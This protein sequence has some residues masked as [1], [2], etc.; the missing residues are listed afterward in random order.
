M[1]RRTAVK[2]RVIRTHH[3]FFHY[4]LKLHWSASIFPGAAV[5]ITCKAESMI[6]LASI[7]LQNIHE[8]TRYLWP[9]EP[10]IW[11]HINLLLIGVGVSYF[12]GKCA[13]QVLNF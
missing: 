11:L 1:L 8:I 2:K 10:V 5:A 7:P 4:A 12:A 13:H 6:F 3:A 9:L